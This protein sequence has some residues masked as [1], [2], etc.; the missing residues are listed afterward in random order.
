ME[1]ESGKRPS[2]L[3]LT[4]M[5]PDPTQP[6]RARC[7][8]FLVDCR[9]R[10][11][12]TPSSHP[13]PDVLVLSVSEVGVPLDPF[14]PV[15]PRQGLVHEGDHLVPAR[16]AVTHGR[17]REFIHPHRQVEG[18]MHVFQERPE[19][20]EPGPVPVHHQE[21]DPVLAAQ[22]RQELREPGDAPRHVAAHAGA[23]QSQ[24]ELAL[25]REEVPPQVHG[26]VDAEVGLVVDLG[27]VEA[28]ERFRLD[29]PSEDD[30]A[31]VGV[32]VLDVGRRPDTGDP[33]DLQW[34]GFRHPQLPV[35]HP[36]DL[37]GR[38]VWRV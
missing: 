27:F 20:L 30:V 31:E 8:V 23:A 9:R 35:E 32:D 11:E 13:R 29:P 7:R 38:V 18:G 28:E 5:S 34:D 15:Q 4:V 17:T 14:A 6:P 3:Q 19:I 1:E 25:G 22:S 16:L 10:C 33:F 36:A 37:A 21:I 24:A 12:I 2:L 26:G